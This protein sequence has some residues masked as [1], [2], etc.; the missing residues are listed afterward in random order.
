[1]SDFSKSLF[2]YNG[3]EPAVLPSR[4]RLASGFTRYS[5]SI[6]LEDLNSLGYTGP[7]VLPELEPNQVAVWNADTQSYDV[8]EQDIALKEDENEDSRVRR[9]IDYLLSTAVDTTDP[10][11]TE[12][13]RDAYLVYYGTLSSLKASKKLLTYEDMPTLELN[14]IT[15]QT[16][17]DAALEVIYAQSIEE[18]TPDWKHMYEV[19]GM[20]GWHDIPEIEARFVKPDFWVPSGTII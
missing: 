8:E 14:S 16:E 13:A 1:M 17:Q 7:F 15:S 9:E 6:T 18:S 4:L 19:Y 3:N 10:D 5:V 20:E 12:K 11:L 2:S